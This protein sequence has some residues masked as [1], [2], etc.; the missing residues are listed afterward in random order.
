M[1]TE[2]TGVRKVQPPVVVETPECT[3]RVAI[4][5]VSAFSIYQQ[6]GREA[7]A[8]TSPQRVVVCKHGVGLA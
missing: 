6:H 4:N 2:D 7:L 1:K 8:Q 5:P 3:L